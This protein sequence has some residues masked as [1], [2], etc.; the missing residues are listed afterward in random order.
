MVDML[1]ALERKRGKRPQVERVVVEGEGQ[2]IVGTAQTGHR[3][4]GQ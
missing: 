3:E 2:A 1:D 4:E